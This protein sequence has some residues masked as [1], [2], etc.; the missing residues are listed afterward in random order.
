VGKVCGYYNIGSALLYFPYKCKELD[1]KSYEVLVYDINAV[2]DI[3][4]R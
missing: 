3:D 4:V 1:M 2:G